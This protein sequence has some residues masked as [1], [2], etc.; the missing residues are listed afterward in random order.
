MEQFYY[1]IPPF[2]PKYKLQIENLECILVWIYNNLSIQDFFEDFSLPSHELVFLQYV[3]WCIFWFK[4]RLKSKHFLLRIL[5][6][7]ATLPD[8]CAP[9]LLPP[10][11]MNGF[12]PWIFLHNS[13]TSWQC[14]S[15][16]TVQQFCTFSIRVHT[17]LTVSF[18]PF[19]ET[20][21]LS[22]TENGVSND[23]SAKD[24]APGTRS[25]HTASDYRATKKE[26]P[27]YLGQTHTPPPLRRV[28][29]NPTELGP[30]C[31]HR[32]VEGRVKYTHTVAMAKRSHC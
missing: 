32:R 14:A 16:S 21:P 6:S 22:H 9:S 29:S 20:E 26:R 10:S 15:S 31:A 12:S 11:F 18:S 17:V 8:L 1:P 7:C 4:C 19:L 23:D 2:I 24:A 27:Y 3:F 25:L 13:V 28:S 5:E 30:M